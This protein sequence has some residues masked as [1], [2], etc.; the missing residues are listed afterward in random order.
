MGY[1]H[2]SIVSPKLDASQ[3]NASMAV[4]EPQSKRKAKSAAWLAVPIVRPPA[5]LSQSCIPY[6]EADRWRKVS[7]SVTPE[8]KMSNDDISWNCLALRGH[9]I[10]ILL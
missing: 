8:R 3:K 5:P 10:Q 9:K 7:A 6:V 1:T 2:A 4:N